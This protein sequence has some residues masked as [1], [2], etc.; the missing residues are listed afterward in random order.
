MASIA[1]GYQL[2]NLA[3]ATGLRDAGDEGF[4]SA[5]LPLSPALLRT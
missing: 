4:D 2:S 3:E 5:P 1:A